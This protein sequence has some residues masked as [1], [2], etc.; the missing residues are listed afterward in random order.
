MDEKNEIGTITR[1]NTGVLVKPISLKPYEINAINL[2]LP[3]YQY[4]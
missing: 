1:L 3:Q 4:D 2:A